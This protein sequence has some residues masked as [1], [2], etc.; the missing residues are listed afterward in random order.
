MTL[1]SSLVWLD[2]KR[3]QQL[4]CAKTF[5]RWLQHTEEVY[6]SPVCYYP[7]LLYGVFSP[8][9]LELIGPLLYE[10]KREE[11]REREWEVDALRNT[12]YNQARHA[13]WKWNISLGR[14]LME[15]KPPQ[16]FLAK[17]SAPRSRSRPGPIKCP[18]REG[19]ASRGGERER[20]EWSQLDFRGMHKNRQREWENFKGVREEIQSKRIRDR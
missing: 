10:R 5:T 18:S 13:H 7:F 19:G 20:W 2:R 4:P 6:S 11:E 1:S 16:Q 9:M 17:S 12:D 8:I 15:V 14:M 3:S